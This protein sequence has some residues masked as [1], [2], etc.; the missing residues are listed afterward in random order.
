MNKRIID[1]TTNDGNQYFEGALAQTYIYQD[2]EGRTHNRR[3]YSVIDLMG[4][5]GGI[6]EG[7][8]MLFCVVILPV[9]YHSFMVQ[10]TEH[11]FY[12]QTSDDKLLPRMKKK[13]IK[14]ESAQL[15]IDKVEKCLSDDHKKRIA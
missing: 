9:S 6:S 11:L 8:I 1:V 7:F 5:V 12:A 3:I 13:L 10:A 15:K 2:R 14:H 4:D